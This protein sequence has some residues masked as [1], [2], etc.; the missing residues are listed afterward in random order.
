M[1]W[2]VMGGVDGGATTLGWTG[3]GSSGLGWAGSMGRVRGGGWGGSVLPA[4]LTPPPA[5]Q[6][7]VRLVDAA[8]DYGATPTASSP[9]ADAHTAGDG[10]GADGGGGGGSG[11]TAMDIEAAVVGGG[12][13]AQPRGKAKLLWFCPVGTRLHHKLSWLWV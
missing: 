10:A 4:S 6:A 12:A 3:L 13:D 5:P 7:N 2:W 1:G 8:Y 11:V 9:A